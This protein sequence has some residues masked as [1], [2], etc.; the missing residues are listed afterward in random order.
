MRKCHDGGSQLGPRLEG[1]TKRFTREDLFRSIVNPSEQ[2]PDRYR[3]I[4]V[5]TTDGFYYRGTIIYESVDGITLQDLDGKTI[6]IN[7]SQIE[8]RTTSEKSLMPDGLLEELK[9]SQWADL[10]A[11]MRSL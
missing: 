10:F 1:V 7:Q 3:A 6:R 2:I 11:Y 9:P 4:I 5:E 8:S